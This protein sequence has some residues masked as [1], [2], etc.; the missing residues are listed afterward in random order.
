MADVHGATPLHYAAQLTD[1]PSPPDGDTRRLRVIDKLL[2]KQVNIDRRDED[3]RTPL[4]WAA[5][6]GQQSLNFCSRS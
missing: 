1:T 6:A 2:S 5:S 4:L 3:K